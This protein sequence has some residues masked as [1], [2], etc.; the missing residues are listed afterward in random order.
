MARPRFCCVELHLT[1]CVFVTFLATLIRQKQHSDLVKFF[2]SL[3]SDFEVSPI[4]PIVP[5]WYRCGLQ[6]DSHQEV[7]KDDDD[8]FQLCPC[9]NVLLSES[10]DAYSFEVE[11]LVAG[12]KDD[13]KNLIRPRLVRPLG[14]VPGALAR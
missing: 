10:L 9:L 8:D 6:P 11:A 4:A 12:S 3:S 13:E 1:G 7:P 14:G 5:R 2:S